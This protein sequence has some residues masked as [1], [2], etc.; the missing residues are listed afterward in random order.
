[1]FGT[2]YAMVI[3]FFFFGMCLRGLGK[4]EVDFSFHGL[5]S[6]LV[7]EYIG[8]FLVKGTAAW[9]PSEADRK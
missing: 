6:L 8:G 4:L 5:P 7:Q 3:V 1:M 9:K 2:N